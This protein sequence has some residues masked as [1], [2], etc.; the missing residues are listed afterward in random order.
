[1]KLTHIAVRNIRR[2]TRRSLLSMGAITLA[3]MIMVILLS[4]LSGITG[5]MRTNIIKYF[6]GDIQL[7]H[8]EYEAYQ[9]QNPLYKHIKNSGDLV[10]GISRIEGVRSVSQR[11]NGVGLIYTS[12]LGKRKI[13]VAY[14][15][16][17]FK[18]EMPIIQFD[19]LVLEGGRL[20]QDGEAE[21]LLG[22]AFA[23]KH[24]YKV[25]DK[26]T[27]NT[28][29]LEGS[30]SVSYDVV[31]IAKFELDE[32]NAGK[33]I[34]PFDVVQNHTKFNLYEMDATTEIVIHL[35]DTQFLNAVKTQIKP[36]LTATGNDG[37]SI[38]GFEDQS[39]IYAFLS[40]AE[41]I[42]NF[43]GI[44]FFLLAS[45]V[46][47]NTT[48][49]VIFERT[50]EIGTLAAIGL[51]GKEIVQLF[52]LES[53]IIAA[54]GSTIGV[55]L[56]IAATLALTQTGID[57]TEAMQGME[58]EINPIFRPK[59]NVLTPIIVLITGIITASLASYVPAKR[60]AKIKPVEA[61][62]NDT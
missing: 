26:F 36:L 22:A 39:T 35:T 33:V 14:T 56:G 28:R 30:W 12:E 32:F 27:M 44:M 45:T 16:L 21:A 42:Y 31:G 18:D 55:L 60:A 61:L 37:I 6:T 11:M 23:K 5:D 29:T 51:K 59:L 13:P 40:I 57:F 46:I 9:D 49:M 10:E 19:K 25:G 48:M 20:P 47:I 54:I 34:L 58:F 3:G 8:E 1:M 2:N 17:S 50:K 38:R 41:A 7:M 24:D 15:A 53:G 62:R 4:L 43:M 52:F